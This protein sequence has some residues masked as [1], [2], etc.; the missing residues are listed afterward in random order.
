V[1]A[2]GNSGHTEFI[3]LLEK[4]TADE[5][6]AVAESALWAIRRLQSSA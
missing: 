6:E 1:I 2:M 5:D 4:L 3:P